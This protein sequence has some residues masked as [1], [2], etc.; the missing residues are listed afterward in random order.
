MVWVGVLLGMKKAATTETS[1]TNNGVKKMTTNEIG[2]MMN[3]NY[4]KA[5]LV[6]VAMGM[7]IESAK[8]AAKEVIYTAIDNY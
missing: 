8:A 5:V 6:F 4:R 3:D 7:D 1:N 2:A